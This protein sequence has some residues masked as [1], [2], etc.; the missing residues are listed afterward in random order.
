MR[1]LKM[2]LIDI[3]L[4]NVSK[5]I[6]VFMLSSLVLNAHPVLNNVPQTVTNK[7]KLSLKYE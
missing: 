4:K 3:S 1:D 5:N 2:S 7:K 6:I